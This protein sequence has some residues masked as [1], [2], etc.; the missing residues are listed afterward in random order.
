[1]R[2][3]LH[4][5][6]GDALL[7]AAIAGEGLALLPDFMVWRDV[8]EGRLET[9]LNDWEVAPIALNLVTPPGALRPARVSVL[10]DFLAER[11]ARAPWA[12]VAGPPVENR[13]G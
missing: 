2:G 10:L 7:P 13:L 6:N 5:D 8:A 11:F 12:L 9:L 4:A 1:M 3:R